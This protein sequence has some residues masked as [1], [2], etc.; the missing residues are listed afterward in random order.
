MINFHDIYY[1]ILIKL[2]LTKVGRIQ[3]CT[4]SD[5]LRARFDFA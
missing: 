5:N 1:K 2:K 3:T 4:I